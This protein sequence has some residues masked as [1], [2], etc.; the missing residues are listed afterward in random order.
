MRFDRIISP[1]RPYLDDEDSL[2]VMRVMH[3]TGT[4]FSMIYSALAFIPLI[5]Q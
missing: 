1:D 4:H 5:E 3:P 2:G